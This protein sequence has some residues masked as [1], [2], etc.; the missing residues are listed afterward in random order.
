MTYQ[1]YI[2]EAINSPFARPDFPV[3]G[4]A[5]TEEVASFAEALSIAEVFGASV[6][7]RDN[8]DK[9]GIPEYMVYAS[10]DKKIAAEIVKQ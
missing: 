1:I 10:A 6:L 4:V 3:H 2:T 8:K 9:N 5:A 7:V